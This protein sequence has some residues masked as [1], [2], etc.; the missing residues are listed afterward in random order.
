MKGA[1]INKITKRKKEKLKLRKNI[2]TKTLETLGVFLQ[3]V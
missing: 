1:G 3:R 2:L